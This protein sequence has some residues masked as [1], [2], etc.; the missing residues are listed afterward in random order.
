[1]PLLAPVAHSETPYCGLRQRPSHRNLMETKGTSK[2]SPSSSSHATTTSKWL[3]PGGTSVLATVR[4]SSLIGLPSRSY[5]I[6]ECTVS[7]KSPPKPVEGAQLCNMQRQGKV[8]QPEP[9]LVKPIDWCVQDSLRHGQSGRGG[10]STTPPAGAQCYAGKG[11]G[12][13]ARKEEAH[14]LCLGKMLLY[15]RLCP[16]EM[17]YASRPRSCPGTNP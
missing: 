2:S 4:T 3:R 8:V 14:T 15:S 17:L 10:G 5:P 11:K 13:A 7:M 9:W 6:S 16:H 12:L 1:M